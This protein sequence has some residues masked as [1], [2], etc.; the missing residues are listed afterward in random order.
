MNRRR[1]I[2]GAALGVT[3][4][5]LAKRFWPRPA[6]PRREEKSRV[7]IIRCDSYEQCHQA[8]EDGLRLLAPSVRGKRVLL[9]PN[10]VEYS[11][12]AAINTHPSV[13]AATA[14][15]LLRR[16]ASEVIV[17]DGPGH[18]RDSEMLI[19]E[20]CLG[21]ELAEVGRVRFVDLNFDVVRRVVP[22]GGFTSFRELWLP[23]T[24][25]SAD[26]IISMPKIKTHHW[27]GVTLSLKNLFG[28]IPGNVY[29][30]PKNVLH[31]EGIDNSI[32]EL[33]ATIP[34]HYV[35]ADGIVAMEGNGPL[36]GPSRHMGCLVFA[37]DPIAADATCCQLMGIEP[38]RIHYLQMV[39]PLGNLPPNRV[40]H[41]GE[42]T[43]SLRQNFVLMPEFRHLAVRSNPG[44]K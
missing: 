18:V 17:A 11:T 27:A 32:A 25:L 31:W 22:R 21:S 4:V 8:I 6:L 10:L 12:K 13:I 24:L 40:I 3:G 15:T 44:N 7:A 1:I 28:C 19:D 14:D 30:W 35:V 16:G 2:E 9:K 23:E 26:V 29:G 33:A 5:A 34:I 37:D 39:A 43:E 36:H 42:P 38:S 20:C 41:A